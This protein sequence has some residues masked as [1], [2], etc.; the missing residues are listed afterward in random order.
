MLFGKIDR[1]AIDYYCNS[2]NTVLTYTAHSFLCSMKHAPIKRASTLFL[3]AVVILIGVIA[4]AICVFT[5]PHAWKGGMQ[6]VPEFAYAV[7][8]GLFGI[9]A[10]IIPF[11]FALLQSF[12]L[13]H[14]IDG[15]NA[16]SELSIK[17]LRNIKFS[18]IA[19][20]MLYA[21]ALPMAFIIAELD[22]APGLVLM[23]SAIAGAPLVVAT[24]AAV[25]QKLVRNALDMKMEHDLT[26]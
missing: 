16:F 14:Y 3:K 9:Y 1:K 7:Y 23:S 2:I 18:G 10:T 8:P 22:D 19:M 13:L 6:G 25:L 11:L 24:F 26:V 20:S 5:F 15:N 4:L 21:L 12:K 17:A